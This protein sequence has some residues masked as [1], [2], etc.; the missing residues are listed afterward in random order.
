MFLTLITQLWSSLCVL[1][2][3][4]PIIILVQMWEKERGFWWGALDLTRQNGLVLEFLEMDS[5][6]PFF[7]LSQEL[8]ML[9]VF[10]TLNMYSKVFLLKP[11]PP[12]AE[13]LFVFHLLNWLVCYIENISNS[14]QS[15]QLC[16]NYSGLLESC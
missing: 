4:F 14:E 16:L 9:K 1:L 5:T 15:Y 2:L 7:L 11:L 12:Y 13:P 10:S 8:I 6:S 3:I